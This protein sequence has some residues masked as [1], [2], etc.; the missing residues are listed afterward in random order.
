[1]NLFTTDLGHKHSSPLA[2]EASAFSSSAATISQRRIFQPGA[3]RGKYS[4]IQILSYFLNNYFFTSKYLHCSRFGQLLIIYQWI[5]QKSPSLEH[6]LSTLALKGK[7]FEVFILPHER[8]LTRFLAI[9]GA[10]PLS[11]LSWVIV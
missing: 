1:M 11:R 8:G 10:A 3:M 9:W 7:C 4:C 6:D 2:N 5:I